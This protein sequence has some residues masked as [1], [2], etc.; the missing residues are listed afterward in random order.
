V[1]IDR[2]DIVLW[3]RNYLRIMRQCKRGNQKFYYLDEMWVN[4]GHTASEYW[5]DTLVSTEREAFISV[6]SS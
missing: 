2:D 4:K 6:L 1:I 5:V 3:R